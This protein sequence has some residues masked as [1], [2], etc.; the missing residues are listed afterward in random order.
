MVRIA[1]GERLGFDQ[2]AIERRGA[3]IECRVYAEDP[4]TGFLPSP[5]VI[6]E[7][8]VPAGP[9]VRDDSGAYSGCTISSNYDPLIS[10]LCVWAPTRDLAIA[11]MRRALAE[12]VVT[13]IRTNLPFH[14]R[15]FEHPEFTSGRYDTGLIDRNKEALLGGTRIPE[16]DRQLYAAAIALSAFKDLT[17]PSLLT[18]TNGGGSETAL[19]PWVAA[20]RSRLGRS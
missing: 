19:S 9:G 5:G 6:E 17:P 12:Y 11:R 2:E 15:L 3:A 20:Q 1:A 18:H 8:R 7:L 14:E 16:Q 13:G 4:S 10:K